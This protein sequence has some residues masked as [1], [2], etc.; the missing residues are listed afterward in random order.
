[1]PERTGLANAQKSKVRGAVEPVFANWLPKVEND[2]SDKKK[3][4]AY[5]IGFVHID[6]AEVTA[7]EG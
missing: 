1:L 7:E 2:K 3:F 6:I 4:K 5:P